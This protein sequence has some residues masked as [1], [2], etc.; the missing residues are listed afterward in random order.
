MS[1]Y[2]E[3]LLPSLDVRGSHGI[4][5]SWTGL[6]SPEVL[7]VPQCA[8]TRNALSALVSNTSRIQVTQV[9]LRVGRTLADPIV[10]IRKL[11]VRS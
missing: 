5:Q 1:G 11:R 2:Q 10:Q 3:N 9:S 7:C 6:L 8:Q 4:V